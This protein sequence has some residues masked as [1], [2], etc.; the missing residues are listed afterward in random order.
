MKMEMAE[1]VLNTQLSKGAKAAIAVTNVCIFPE[2][3][4]SFLTCT[5]KVNCFPARVLCSLGQRPIPEPLTAFCG[6][7]RGYRF[8]E[9]QTPPVFRPQ[10]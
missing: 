9:H 1:L 6:H 10:H 3:M 7:S 2:A 4:N 5:G 8:N